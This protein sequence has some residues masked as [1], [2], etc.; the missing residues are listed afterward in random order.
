MARYGLGGIVSD[1]FGQSFPWGTLVI[2]VTGSFII[3]IFGALT[4]PEGK[5]APQSRAL[6]TMV[7]RVS[8]VMIRIGIVRNSFEGSE[9]IQR[10]N[11]S[12]PPGGSL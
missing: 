12:P 9:R 8:V 11:S 1:K 2:N 7:E 6:A 5:M 3:G 4:A 10:V